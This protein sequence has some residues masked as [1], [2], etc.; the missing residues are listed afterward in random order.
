MSD[1]NLAYIV[2][3]DT[4]ACY[5]IQMELSRHTKYYKSEA[6]KNGEE[7]IE[8]LIKCADQSKCLPDLI[9]LDINM[10]IM[11]GWEFLDE[12][13]NLTYSKDI[14]V[15]IL[16]SSIN[17]EDREKAK[18]YKDVKGFMSKPIT[19]DKLDQILELIKV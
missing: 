11:D 12:F 15:I 18:K 3:D 4:I 10:P 1:I 8:T 7:A 5:V 9:L 6:F 2:E 17:P 16:T 19:K 14:S 13:S